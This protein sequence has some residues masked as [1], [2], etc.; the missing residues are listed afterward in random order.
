MSRS[1]PDGVDGTMRSANCDPHWTAFASFIGRL[2]LFRRSFPSAR[3]R[4]CVTA[5][6]ALVISAVAAAAQQYPSR[7]VTIIVPYP[8]GGPTDQLAR[9]MGPALSEKLGQPFIIE[10]MSGGGTTIATARVA[11]AAPDGYTLLLHNLQISA[12]VSLYH[13]LPFD[14]EKDLTPVIFV[15]H[16]PL[17]LTGR[18][19][20]V[21][22]TLKELIATMRTSV[23]KMAHPG[24]GATGHLATCLF[25]QEAHVTV[26]QIPY[27]G[28]APA[29]Q[30]VAGG[31]VDLFFAT[32]Q[33]VVEQAA[34]GQIKAYGITAQQVSPHFPHAAS[35]VQELGLKLEILYWHALFAP[36]GTPSNIVAR[37][38]SAVQDMLAYPVILKS[39]SES[40]VA[41]FPQDQRSPA[42]ARAL[43]R[44]EIARWSEVVRTNNIQAP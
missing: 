17:V 2:P 26:D 1:E 3:L 36:A 31:H 21:P 11:R 15:N 41:P 25:A 30:D 32:P 29:L 38:N 39:W 10:N 33:S 14:T 34:S 8:A 7:P 35:L 4:S 5:V 42:A 12:N 6:L 9:V 23:L 24:V 22:N 13:N 27:R 40:D 19:T 43:L 18:T 44:D 28:A 37:L 16:N 20:L